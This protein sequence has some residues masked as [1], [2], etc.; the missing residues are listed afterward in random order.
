MPAGAKAVSTAHAALLAATC[1]ELQQA[2]H[3]ARA[4]IVQRAASLMGCSVPTA[5]RRLGECGFESG[6]KR[7]SDAGQCALSETELRLVAGVLRAS[8]NQKGQRMPLATALDVLH[9]SGQLTRRL[10]ESTVSR[11]L[12]QRRMH[13]E[14]MAMP[15]PSV[16]MASKHPNHVWQIDSTTGAYYYMP[17]GRL[18]WMDETA[19]YKNK[20]D[21]LV[22]AA[23]DLLT[24]YAVADHTSNAFRVRYYLGGETEAN[25]LDFVT[26]AMAKGEDSPMHGVPYHLVMDPGAANKGLLM[27]R[28]C[29][30]AGINLMHHQAGAAR[31]TGSVEKVHDLVRMHFETRFRFT[32][33][34]QVTLETLNA[35][36]QQWA[37]AYCGSRVQARLGRPR[38][39]AWMEISYHPGA[40]RMATLE[41][42]RAAANFAPEARRVANDKSVSYAGRRYDLARVP[43]VAVGLKVTL[44]VNLFRSPSIDVLFTCPDTGAETWHVVAPAQSDKFGFPV[45]APVWGE[46]HP[47]TARNSSV[48]AN[49]KEL[50]KEAYALPTIKEAEAARK[51]H[52]QAY[53]GVV[54][55]MADVKTTPLPTFMP[56]KGAVVELPQRRVEAQRI[57]TTEMAMRL[58]HRLGAAYTPQVYSEL[59]RLYPEGAVLETEEDTLAQRFAAPAPE[60]AQRGAEQAGGA[61]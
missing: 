2:P 5:Y 23:S 10:H 7:R 47:Q 40:L 3:S 15:T 22:K 36:I 29:E 11:Q 54:D 45:G 33:P 31:V 35:S 43:G 20:P 50:L 60:A 19:F 34:T 41:G 39:Q 52:R 30:C 61:A 42:L 21:N 56:R 46:E 8:L 48:D 44:Q 55:A 27:R 12:Y 37:L 26:W 51:R 6:R 49:R 28:F 13:P 4:P 38:M 53:A 59:A 16:V 58:R 14:Q 24:R 9:A 57:S 32:D 25:L 17:G 18:R 1:Q